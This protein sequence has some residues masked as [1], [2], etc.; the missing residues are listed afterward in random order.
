M[1]GEAVEKVEEDTCW[2]VKVKCPYCVGFHW[3]GGSGFR[4]SHCG[5]G[6]YKI[7]ESPTIKI[8][9]LINAIPSEK[10]RRTVLRS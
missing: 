6:E 4:M 3:H 9:P 2:R 1:M 8:V 10:K 7:I 5:I